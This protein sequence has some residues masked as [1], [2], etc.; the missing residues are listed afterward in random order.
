MPYEIIKQ[1]QTLTKKRNRKQEKK[2]R[3][4]QKIQTQCFLFVCDLHQY[5]Q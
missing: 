2:E 1:Q 5:I 4:K 3:T